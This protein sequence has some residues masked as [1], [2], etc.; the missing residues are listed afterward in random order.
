MNHFS[1]LPYMFTFFMTFSSSLVPAQNWPSWRG[2]NGDGTTS[3]TGYPTRWDSITNGL[4]KRPVPGT[5][6]SSPIIWEDKRFLSSAVPETQEKQ[7]L[8]Y[9]CHTGHLFWQ[10]TVV[11]SPFESKHNDNS[12]ASGTPATDGKLVF[13]SFLDGESV[14]VAAHDFAG[15]RIWIQRPGKFSSPHGYSCSPVLYEDKVIINGNSLEDSF[16]AAMSKTDGQIIWKSHTKIQPT[17]SVR[18]SSGKWLV[19]RR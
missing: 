7:L 19:R 18:P 14:V 5:G 13:T 10:V 2:P 1:Y 15:N 9:D 16:M 4:W 8:C 17:V 6:Y 12:Y 3:E 11:K